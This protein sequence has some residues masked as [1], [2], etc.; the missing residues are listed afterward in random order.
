[1]KTF[2]NK[3]AVKKIRGKYMIDRQHGIFLR[4]HTDINRLLILL[5]TVCGR[6]NRFK[7][8]TMWFFPPF[9]KN[10]RCHYLLLHLCTKDNGNKC[11]NANILSWSFILLLVQDRGLNSY[12][13]INIEYLTS[14]IN[15]ELPSSFKSVMFY[16]HCI[17][18]H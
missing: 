1:M 7:A 11:A 12:A 9:K 6:I 17:W 3:M 15:N 14:P 2:F 5:I 16:K 13:S 8:S 4:Y 10:I 18:V